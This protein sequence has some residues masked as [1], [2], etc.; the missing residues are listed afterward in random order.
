[1]QPL[2]VLTPATLTDF[3]AGA[4]VMPPPPNTLATT[5]PTPHRYCLRLT[6]PAPKRLLPS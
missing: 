4:A 6:T 2:Y 5:Q 1:M 3:R